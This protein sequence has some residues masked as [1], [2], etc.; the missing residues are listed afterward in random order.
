MSF[1]KNIAIK[2]VTKK[3]IRQFTALIETALNTDEFQHGDINSRVLRILNK[4]IETIENQDPSVRSTLNIDTK[5][6]DNWKELLL[7]LVIQATRS[8]LAYDLSIGENTE[9]LLIEKVFNCEMEFWKKRIKTNLAEH[10]KLLFGQK[11]S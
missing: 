2:S 7:C 8:E 11:S 6:I 5:K 1:L 3:R 9:F 4:L 10:D